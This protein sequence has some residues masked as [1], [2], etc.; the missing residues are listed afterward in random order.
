MHEECFITTLDNP[1]D[2]FEEFASWHMFDV[3]KGYFTCNYVAR[4]IQLSDDMTQKEICEET[5]RVVDSI[6]LNDPRPIYK[7]IWKSNSNQ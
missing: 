5:E 1:F 2:Y 7:K 4:L 3:E 6:M